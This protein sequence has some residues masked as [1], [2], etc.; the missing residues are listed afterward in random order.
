MG[1]V[2][3]TAC[4]ENAMGE[5]GHRSGDYSVREPTDG[6]DFEHLCHYII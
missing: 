6:I 3:Y 1:K 2:R 4:Y 5:T